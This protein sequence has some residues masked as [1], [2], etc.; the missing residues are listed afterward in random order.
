MQHT[1]N[2]TR[3]RKA[4]IQLLEDLKPDSS[5]SSEPQD[6][7]ELVKQVAKLEYWARAVGIL[8]ED[9]TRSSNHQTLDDPDFDNVVLKLLYLGSTSFQR[10]QNGARAGTLWDNLPSALRGGSKSSSHIRVFNQIQLL[11]QL[12]R[13]LSTLIPIKDDPTFTA[14]VSSESPMDV[15]GSQSAEYTWSGDIQLALS[16][17]EAKTAKGKD[18]YQ[19]VDPFHHKY[20]GTDRPQFSNAENYRRGCSARICSAMLEVLHYTS[21]RERRANGCSV[22]SSI[23]PGLNPSTPYQSFSGFTALRVSVRLCSALG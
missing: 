19:T 20:L 18:Q 1:L 23:Y 14:M 11:P 9:S 17:L 22:E 10:L 2:D 13:L 15:M 3:V 7:D 21:G 5:I 4:V 12:I 8:G 16:D 6:G